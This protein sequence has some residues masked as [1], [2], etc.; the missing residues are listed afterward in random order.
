MPASRARRSLLASAPLFLACLALLALPV[1]P[2]PARAQTAGVTLLWTAPGDDGM[3]GRARR[4]DL[5]IST[6]PISGAGT[7]S[8]WTAATV[9]DMSGRVSAAARAPDPVAVPNLTA[10]AQ[11]YAAL[12]AGDE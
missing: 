12:R 8:W 6:R 10:A 4:H 11:Y 1:T 5:R 9:A 7:L 3:T 2:A